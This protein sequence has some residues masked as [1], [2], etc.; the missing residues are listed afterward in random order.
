MKMA[1]RKTILTALQLEEVRATDAEE[2]ATT[3]LR[4]TRSLL[5]Q[6]LMS[7]TSA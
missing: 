6:S 7:M 4:L 2:E 3:A 5:P 1:K